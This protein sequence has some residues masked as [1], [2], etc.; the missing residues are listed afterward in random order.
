MSHSLRTGN[1]NQIPA[2]THPHTAPAHLLPFLPAS[3]LAGL[4]CHSLSGPVSQHTANVL[5]HQ[6]LWLGSHLRLHCACQA[7]KAACTIWANLCSLA[8]SLLLVSRSS[9]WPCSCK[10][11][12]NFH[13]LPMS[14]ATGGS[15]VL[16]LLYCPVWLSSVPRSY[17]I[18]KGGFS[19]LLLNAALWRLALSTL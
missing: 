9:P 10:W 4:Q 7:L 13:P 2:N 6:L 3:S 1:T 17:E 8:P 12:V 11:R 18:T 5:T 14:S 16:W 19:L 15:C